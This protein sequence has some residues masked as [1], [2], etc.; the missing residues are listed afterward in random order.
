MTVKDYFAKQ[1]YK[2]YVTASATVVLAGVGLYYLMTPKTPKSPK[3]PKT[4]KHKPTNRTKKNRPTGTSET[5]STAG[6]SK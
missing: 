1:D 6:K 2:F 3:T 4:P 5:S